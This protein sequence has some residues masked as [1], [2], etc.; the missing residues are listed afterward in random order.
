M[1]YE[2]LDLQETLIFY[3]YQDINVQGKIQDKIQDM[4]DEIR[5]LKE[6]PGRII[7]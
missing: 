4:D 1:K 7:L 6:K 2:D 3:K 5:I